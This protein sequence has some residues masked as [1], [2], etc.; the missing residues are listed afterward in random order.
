[1]KI[2]LVKLEKNSKVKNFRSEVEFPSGESYPPLSLNLC[3]AE[4][5][6]R[7]K[8][9]RQYHERAEGSSPETMFI[10]SI[11][12]YHS[13]QASTL[14]KWLMVVMEAAGID[15]A[16]Y[17]AN[18]MRSASASSM[19][20]KGLSIKQVQ[21]RGFWSNRTRTFSIYY[22]RSAVVCSKKL[23]FWTLLEAVLSINVRAGGCIINQCSPPRRYLRWNIYFSYL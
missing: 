7:T 11:R 8:S 15:I 6:S 13:V 23:Y 20:S 9:C 1:M 17:K 2:P 10:S 5:L 12:P 19:R 21:D 14:G 4:Y 16:S 22:D 3:L 18:S